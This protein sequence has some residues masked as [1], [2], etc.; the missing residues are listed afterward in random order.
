MRAVVG[1]HLG[2]LIDRNVRGRLIAVGISGSMAHLVGGWLAKGEVE[3]H[4][5]RMGTTG[6]DALHDS[7]S[8]LVVEQA[9]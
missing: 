1:G 4:G 6:S 8:G 9:I 2:P 7:L 5:V 3:T